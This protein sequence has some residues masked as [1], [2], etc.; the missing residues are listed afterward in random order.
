MRNQNAFRGGAYSLTISVVVLAILLVLNIFVSALPAAVTRYDISASKLYS[1][2]SNTKAVVNAL[3]QDVTIYWVVQSGQEDSTDTYSADDVY[4]TQRSGKNLPLDTSR[5]ESYLQSITNLNPV[6]YVSY[7]VTD[8][9]LQTYGLDAPELTITVDYTTEGEDGEEIADTFVLYVS[10]DPEDVKAAEEAEDE[11]QE[12]EISAYVR[13]GESQIVYKISSSSYKTLAAMSYND[14]RHPEVIWADFS[15]VQQIDISLEG[16]NYT[17]TSE[18]DGED[19]IWSYQEEDLE[20]ADLQSTL[21]ALAADEFT[22]ERPTEREEVSLTVHLDNESF[23]QVEIKLYRYDGSRCLAVVDGE[24]ASLVDRTAVVDLIEAV[25][26]I[27]L[28]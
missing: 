27:V 14:L 5:V 24:S 11:D 13:V 9:E 20:I 19:H 26:A 4:F 12:A 3:E 15:D 8:E 18:K 7:N 2:T 10:P 6:N 23:P 1:I 21:E 22:D 28:D 16:N 25:H 17:L